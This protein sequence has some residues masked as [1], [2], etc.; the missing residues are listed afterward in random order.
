MRKS[1]YISDHIEELASKL[2]LLIPEE[3][4]TVPSDIKAHF[5]S[6]LQ[7]AFAKLDLVNREEFD[8]QVKVLQRTRAKVEALEEKLAEQKKAHTAKIEDKK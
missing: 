4:K 7:S 8:T 5:K 3:A 1:D 2:L 6:T